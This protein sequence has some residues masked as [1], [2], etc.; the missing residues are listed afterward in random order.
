MKTPKS[1]QRIADN[2]G[3]FVEILKFRNQIGKFKTGYC[4]VDADSNELCEFEPINQLGDK[5]KITVMG[6]GGFVKYVKS[7]RSIKALPV[8]PGYTGYKFRSLVSGPNGRML[9]YGAINLIKP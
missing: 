6:K 3:L 9:S 8:R 2:K 7:L 5:W 1:I 4:I